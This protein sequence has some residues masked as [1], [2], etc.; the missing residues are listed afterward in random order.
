MSRR[1]TSP[2]QTEAAWSRSRVEQD[3]RADAATNSPISPAAVT[4]PRAES[5]TV[6]DLRWPE[7]LRVFGAGV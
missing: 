3:R 1:T 2:L 7:I 4:N 6:A 5:L